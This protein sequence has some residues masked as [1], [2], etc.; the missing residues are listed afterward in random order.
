[1][2]NVAGLHMSLH[3]SQA[4][5]SRNILHRRGS[6]SVTGSLHHTVVP[7]A[8]MLLTPVDRTLR[9]VCAIVRR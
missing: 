9:L 3:E 1:M 5:S 2:R 7:S 6:V 8:F 4:R